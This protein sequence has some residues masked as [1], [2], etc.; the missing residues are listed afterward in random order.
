MNSVNIVSK[1]KKFPRK[2][3]NAKNVKG[4]KH[5]EF[6]EKSALFRERGIV[7]MWCYTR[8]ET[9]DPMLYLENEEGGLIR[10]FNL[11]NQF[12]QIRN[13]F[14]K[15]NAK[16]NKVLAMKRKK[17]KLDKQCKEFDELITGKNFYV[18]NGK[19]FFS[20]IEAKEEALKLKPELR[21][22]VEEREE[23]LEDIRRRYHMPYVKEYIDIDPHKRDSRKIQR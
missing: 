3:V 7:D 5:L 21:Q 20:Y 15:A 2:T 17:D 6:N 14:I 19:Q 23:L 4:G 18:V 12:D 11:R 8:P 16:K 13:Y 10:D 9:G 1:A 22:V